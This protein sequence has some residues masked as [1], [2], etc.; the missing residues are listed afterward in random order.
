MSTLLTSTPRADGF[1][2]PGEFEPQSQVWML[3]PQRPDT[4][5]DG[6][7]PAQRAWVAVASAISRFV[8]VTIGVNHDQFENARAM[9]PA[10]VRVVE[11][12][13]NDAWMRD[14][15]PI[16]VSDDT[17]EVR[18]V[19]FDFNAWGGLYDGLYFPWD[20][21]DMVPRKVA[22]IER[23]DRYRA[24][25]VLEGGA[26]TVDGQGTLIT[27]EECL[28]SAGRNPELTREQIECHLDDYLGIDKVIWLPRGVDPDETNGHVDGV[29]FYVSPGV[30]ALSWTDDTGHPLYDVFR[31]A[32]D[33]LESQTDAR[34]RRFDVRL[35]PVTA[36][37]IVVTREE[38][39]G[40]DTVEGAK[41][42]EAGPMGMGTYANVLICNGGVIVPLCGDSNDDEAVAAIR[43]LFPDREVVTVTG[44][45][46]EMAG[47]NV[48]CITQQQPRPATTRE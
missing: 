10:H 18:L 47:G 34:D 12:S 2:M 26:I 37:E 48:H 40:I 43:A 6:G 42:R 45:E 31:G 3:W 21:D 27:T 14:C 41:P 38:A 33:V 9:L 30:V 28:L 1:R 35:L 32:R 24:P 8:P 44:R 5:R 7:K 15:G 17:G 39:D 20:K 46:I 13:S 25:M 23:V 16:F 11:L 4:W 29:C 22:E 36:D 19:D